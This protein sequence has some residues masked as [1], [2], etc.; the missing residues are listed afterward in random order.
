MQTEILLQIGADF[1]QIGTATRKHVY[2]G[3]VVF[4]KIEGHNYGF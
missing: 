2:S 4:I 1:L 3:K